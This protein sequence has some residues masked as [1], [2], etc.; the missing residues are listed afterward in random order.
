[1]KFPPQGQEQLRGFPFSISFTTTMVRSLLDLGH[2]TLDIGL[3]NF[4][5]SNYE[6][7]LTW[8]LLAV[9]S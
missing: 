2:W 7:F 4:Y 1:M 8:Y 3:F 9:L 5:P 6:L